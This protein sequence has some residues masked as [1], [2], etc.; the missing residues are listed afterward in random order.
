MNPS[1]YSIVSTV[2]TFVV[3]MMYYLVVKPDFVL[4]KDESDDSDDSDTSG[5]DNSSDTSGND[6]SSD[7]SGN[8]KKTKKVCLRLCLV[9]SL[10][11]ASAV[12]LLVLGVSTLL[13][14]PQ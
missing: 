4:R 1:T 8:M 9:Y 7:T 5:N 11:F 12:G 13:E 2:I 6:N 10:L 3:L 14:K